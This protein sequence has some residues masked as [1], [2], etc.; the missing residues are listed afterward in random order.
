MKTESILIH[1]IDPKEFKAIIR[2]MISE[3]FEKINHEIQRVIGDDD[4]VSTGTAC[5]ILG[6]SSKVFRI[7]VND[8]HFTVF[9]HMK[10]R[11]FQR[12]ELLEYRNKYKTSRINRKLVI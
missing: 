7:L 1:Q 11:R 12:S 2:E 3:E 9:H 6:I 5:R 4:L 8:G 10:E